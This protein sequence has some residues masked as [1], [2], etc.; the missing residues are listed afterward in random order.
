MKRG[1]LWIEQFGVVVCI[2]I[3][4]Q[5]VHPRFYKLLYI[6]FIP[7][8]NRL[9][10]FHPIQPEQSLLDIPLSG[11]RQSVQ[12]SH[13][14]SELWKGLKTDIFQ[15]PEKSGL[16]VFDIRNLPVCKKCFSCYNIQGILTLRV[17][18]ETPG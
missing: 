7:F 3:L 18:E 14:F 15:S 16:P 17:S 5:I 2:T 1:F 11:S 4:K 9:R 6:L 13:K 12:G 8:L 10:P